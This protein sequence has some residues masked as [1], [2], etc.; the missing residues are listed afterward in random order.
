MRCIATLL[1]A[2]LSMG[3]LAPAVQSNPEA[4]LPACCRQNGKHQCARLSSSHPSENSSQIAIANQKCR[5]FPI[6]IAPVC[7]HVVLG[8][9]AQGFVLLTQNLIESGPKQAGHRIA[10]AH[11]LQR[12]PPS[13]S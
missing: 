3:M 5:F 2:V 13:L 11:N 8:L 6:T 7:N 1:L 10:A 4:K 9:R 12:G